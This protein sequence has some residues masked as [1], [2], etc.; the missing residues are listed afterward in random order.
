MDL[1]TAIGLAVLFGLGFVGWGFVEYVI[2][3]LLSHRFSTPVSPLHWQHHR[4]PH[5][6][7]TA[8]LAWV[9]GAAVAYGV[10]GLSIGAVPAAAL[11]SGLLLGFARYEYVHWR[12]HFREPRT[13]RQRLLRNHHLAHH[14]RDPTMYCGVTTRVWD[15]VF[16]TLP[17]GCEADYARVAN[18]PPLDG[19]SNIR[20]IWNP[21]FAF[22]RIRKAQRAT[23]TPWRSS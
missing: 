18:R 8:P 13:A 4:E 6:V 23:G 21:R 2:H 3:G 15:R 9:P 19:P 7:F 5:A 16:G 1:G 22:A 14:F 17:D 12:I 10:V 20:L 11:L